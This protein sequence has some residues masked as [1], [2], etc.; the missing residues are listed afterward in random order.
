MT[1]DTAP[2]APAFLVIEDW[3]PGTLC[4][5]TGRAGGVSRAPY[6]TLNLGDHV[7][8]DPAAVLEN[9]ARVA[10]ALG[11]VPERFIIVRQVHGARV[12]AVEGPP[13]E[14]VEAD[15]MVTRE[16]D[17]ALAVL[18]ADCVP[19]ALADETG[20][21]GVVHAGWRGL[22]AGVV[23]AALEQFD[24]ASTHAY[25]GPRISGARYQVGPEVAEH[26]RDVP[27]ALTPD[28]GDRSRLDVGGVAVAHLTQLGVATE[29]ITVAPETTDDL[30]RFFSDRAQRPCGRFGLVV[31]RTV[32]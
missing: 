20:L 26:F 8:D 5:V 29:R 2:G 24:V 17:L 11:V 30:A 23:A 12:V 10:R 25:V 7:G 3:H 13:D 1:S 31:R 16:R 22:A 6:D 9:R 19:I 27:G 21:V 28:A 18:V 32:A 15:A 14:G 4:A